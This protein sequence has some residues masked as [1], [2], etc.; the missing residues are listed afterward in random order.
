MCRKS[1][2]V[3]FENSVTVGSVYLNRAT[4]NG[5][6]LFI[7]AQIGDFFVANNAQFNNEMQ[8]ANFNYM[9]IGEILY[10]NQASFSGPANFAYVNVGRN[11]EAAE[12]VFNSK[13]GAANF[14]EI[15]VENAVLFNKTIFAG[16][17]SF[18]H[19]LIHANLEIKDTQY[20]NASKQADFGNMK[21]GEIVF[22]DRAVFAGQ[23]NFNNLEVGEHLSANDAQFNNKK[24]PVNFANMR[25]GKSASFSQAVFHG[26]VYFD[27]SSIGMV[28]ELKGVQIDN[29]EQGA[30]FSKTSIKKEVNIE[31]A[32]ISGLLNFET[33]EI[34]GALFI[35]DTQFTSQTSNVS[36]NFTNAKYALLNRVVFAGPVSF[37]SASIEHFNATDVTWA[38]GQDAVNFY[39]F[40]FRSIAIEKSSD[41]DQ[42]GETLAFLDR[43]SAYDGQLYR[44]FEHM[45][46]N[47]GRLEYADIAYARG[48]MRERDALDWWYWRW[49]WNLF[50]EYFVMYGIFP[51]RALLW[52]FLFVSLGNAV[53]RNKE[54]MTPVGE[55]SPRYN[56]FLYSLDLFIP[57]SNE[58]YITIQFRSMQAR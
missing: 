23:A 2:A 58:N 54:K 52:L 24:E 21:I 30:S 39:G 46:R 18:R 12:A 20:T 8:E 4:F 38:A 11:I 13:D 44:D 19:A 42:L 7:N 50:L 10:L 31:K 45:L 55:V 16:P 43:S 6:V 57:F 56:S 49:W 3:N 26:P 48:K 40:K 28:L 36:F 27:L 47:N 29:Q 53:F 35:I 41:G 25:I 34:D 33:A 17:V 5:A 15:K 37:N 51:L 14:A 9:K 1:R 22:M 32:V